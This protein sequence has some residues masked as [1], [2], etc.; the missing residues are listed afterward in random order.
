MQ[1]FIQTMMAT[2]D[3]KPRLSSA[4]TS[5]CCT[6]SRTQK[7]PRRY[8]TPRVEEHAMLS[9]LAPALYDRPSIWR[10]LGPGPE[11]LGFRSKFILRR[12]NSGVMAADE[13]IVIRIRGVNWLARQADLKRRSPSSRS[14]RVPEKVFEGEGVEVYA[15]LLASIGQ[16][17]TFT[18]SSRA[19][20]FNARAAKLFL[21]SGRNV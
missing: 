9:R 6:A 5:S 19:S 4:I 7:Y 13:F 11:S 14:R 17:D 1:T 10:C 16:D 8:S 20:L 12:I 15:L 3:E 21:S 18:A 2:G